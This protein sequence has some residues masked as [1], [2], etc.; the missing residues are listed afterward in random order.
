MPPDGI[1]GDKS[2][3]ASVNIRSKETGAQKK[4]DFRQKA[5]L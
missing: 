3:N 5:L 1:F 2:K 4:C